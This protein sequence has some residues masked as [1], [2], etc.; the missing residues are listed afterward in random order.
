LNGV[1]PNFEWVLLLEEQD[2]M[3][4]SD[5]T[6]DFE[7]LPTN[8]KSLIN[9]VASNNITR[10]ETALNEVKIFTATVWLSSRRAASD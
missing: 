1:E 9:A 10:L 5:H 2:T 6:D 7:C 4:T 3:F 8:Q